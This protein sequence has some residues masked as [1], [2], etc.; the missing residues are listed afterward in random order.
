MNKIIMAS[1]AYSVPFQTSQLQRN[2][3]ENIWS[4]ISLKL[5]HLKNKTIFEINFDQPR[6]H[7]HFN[8]RKQDSG[9]KELLWACFKGTLM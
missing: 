3:I 1:Q 5:Y 9:K 2:Q 6:K 7:V 4:R 8:F